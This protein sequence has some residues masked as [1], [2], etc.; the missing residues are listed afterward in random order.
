[1]NKESVAYQ[2]QLRWQRIYRRNNRERAFAL[3]GSKCFFCTQR[4]KKALVFHERHGNYHDTRDCFRSVLRNP[5][6]FVV[7]CKRCHTGVHFCME[8]FGLD[9]EAI[10]EQMC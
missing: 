7:V 5:Q 9:W 3:L 4:N 8:T 2:N 1:M 10:K 6:D